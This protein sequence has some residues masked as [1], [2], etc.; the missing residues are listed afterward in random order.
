MNCSKINLIYFS[1][2]D[3]TKSTLESI[4]DELSIEPITTYNI[5]KGQD[6]EVTFSEN[7]ITIFGMPVY[8]GRIPQLCIN[9]LNKFKGNKTPTIVVCVYGNRDYDDALLELRDIVA[10]NG[11]Q[12]I[13]AGAFIGQHSIF[14]ST[15]NGRPDEIDR[16]DAMTFGQATI[17]LLQ[18]I[19]DISQISKIEVKGN[20][21]YKEIK[22]IPLKPKGNRKCDKCG[23]CVRN[24]PTHAIELDNPRKTNKEL[25][26]SCAHCIHICPQDARHFG[27]IIYKLAANKFN[28]A[29][30]ERKKSE[31]Y[32]A[33][34]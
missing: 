34:I 23:K 31:Q 16:N 26:I 30:T 17:R 21:P 8:A 7:E 29:Y 22:S 9:N 4:A 14:P 1:A 25:C 2:T 20:Y 12:I 6:K 33:T 28:K 3:T 11:F 19:S 5:T 10:A 32:F 27:G 24:C 15:G 18:N 13:A